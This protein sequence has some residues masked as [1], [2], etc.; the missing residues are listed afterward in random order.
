MSNTDKNIK[1]GSI[2]IDMDIARKILPVAGYYD[3]RTASDERIIAILSD[4][5]ST[6]GASFQVEEE[7]K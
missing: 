5:F 6:Y 1:Q 3:A 2:T 4:L 7:I